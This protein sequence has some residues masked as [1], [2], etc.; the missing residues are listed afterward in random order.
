[1]LAA[2]TIFS[3]SSAPPCPFMSDRCGSNW[4]VPSMVTSMSECV[5]SEVSSIPA[6]CARCAVRSLVGMPLIWK[7]LSRHFFPSSS[8]MQFAV[9]P[10]PKPT[11]MPE[12]ICFTAASAQFFLSSSCRFMIVSFF[13]GRSRPKSYRSVS[14]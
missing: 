5:S 9:L 13:P 12:A 8:I 1:M 2:A 14:R 6:V 7:L 11:I 3:R 10:V 4:S